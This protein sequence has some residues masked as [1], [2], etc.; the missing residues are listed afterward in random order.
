MRK[1]FRELR[2][3]EVFRSAGLYV[4]IAWIVIEVSSVLLPTFDAPQWIL[5]WLIIVAM[6]GFPVALVLSWIFDV[7]EKGIVVQDAGT[8]SDAMP[9]GGR[10]MDFVVIGVLSVALIVSVYLNVTRAPEVPAE[11]EPLTVLI[12]DFD[13]RTGNP[14]FDGSLEQA[15]AI[16]IEGAAFIDNYRRDAALDQALKLDLGQR[17]DE[18]T[19]RLVGV[20]ENVNIVLAGSIAQ[21]GERLQLELRAVEPASGKE[22]GA[23]RVRADNSGEVLGAMNRLAADIREDLGDDAASVAGLAS[24]ES[25]TTTSLQAI[26]EYTE[27]QD[28]ARDSRDEEAIEHYR[29][30]VELDPQFARAWSGWGLSAFKIGRSSEA[31]ELWAKALALQDRMTDRERYRTFGLYYTAVSLNFDKA[32]ENYQQLVEKFPADGA[33]NNNLAILY[34]FTAQYDK[35]LKQSEQLLKIYPG[36]TLYR[37]NHAQYA[38]YA[39]DMDTAAKY[40]NDVIAADPEFF[41]S[42]MILAIVNLDRGDTE[43]ARQQYRAMAA[44]GTRGASLAATGLADIA[45]FEHRLEDAIALLSAGIEQDRADANERGVAAKSIALAQAQVAQENVGRAMELLQSMAESRGDGQLVPMAEI[46]AQQKMFSEA[47]EIA[48]TYRSQ[49]RPTARAY[50]SLIDGLIAFQQGRYTDAIEAYRKAI[51]STDLWLVR[52]HLGQAYL[53]A[54]YPAEA[55]SEFA[56]CIERRGEAGGLFFDDVPTWRY[57][58]A[59]GDWKTAA[60]RELSGLAAAVRPDLSAGSRR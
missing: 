36:R 25:V 40:A 57:T 13:N 47:A 39:G 23:S 14:L 3:R 55:S 31:D 5:R 22:R 32:I 28:L 2:R 29:K 6:I 59:L 44:S 45:A 46:Y 8:E 48:D 4:G 50:A 43:A 54:G 38:L 53:A 1:L 12:A 9:A 21:D 24:G 52:F 18:E 27:A 56:S 26:K 37:A 15:L 51:E 49:L 60:D 16:G 19:A 33:G 7:T 42:Y 10:K 35:A 41:K 58:A 11:H 20:R 17:L 34:T 30:A